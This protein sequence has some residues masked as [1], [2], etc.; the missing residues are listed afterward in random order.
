M[1]QA[2]GL[3][4]GGVTVQMDGALS[5]E[6]RRRT[7]AAEVFKDRCQVN[8]AMQLQIGLGCVRSGVVDDEVSV[9]REERE[10]PFHVSAIRAVSVGVDQL[11]YCEPVLN[12]SRQH[13]QSASVPSKSIVAWVPSQN[14]LLEECP[15]RHI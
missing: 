12:L 4:R 11:A 7:V 2:V 1:S 5:V 15:Q 8:L 10:L 14:G 3:S 9:K 6:M 13:R